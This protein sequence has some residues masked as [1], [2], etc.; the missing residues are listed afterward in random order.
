MLLREEHAS[1][2]EEGSGEE[3][4]ESEEEIKKMKPAKK[5]R[6]IVMMDSDSENEEEKEEKKEEKEEKK[7]EEEEDEEEEDAYEVETILEKKEEDGVTKYLIQWLGY[8]KEEDRTWEPEANLDCAEKIRLF[9]EAL[10]GK[11]PVEEREKDGKELVK[12]ESEE[13]AAG[14]C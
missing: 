14:A 9:E 7:E 13:L 8:D 3:E 11:K 5:R 2:V 4:E 10:G 12:D 6:R 1:I